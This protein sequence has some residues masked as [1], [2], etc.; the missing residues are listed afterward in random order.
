MKIVMLD[1]VP[2]DQDDIDWS[3]YEALGDVTYY[4]RTSPEQTIERCRDAV[5]ACTNKV[6]MTR[7][8]IEACPQLKF[9]Q[10][11]ATGTNVIDFEA[12]KERGIQVANIPSYSTASV[13]QHTFALL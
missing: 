5:V 12:C 7:E 10:V 11:M 4:D 13:V 9:I 2:M 3:A 6:L 8:V 1:R